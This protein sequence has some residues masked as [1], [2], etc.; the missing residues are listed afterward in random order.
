MDSADELYDYISHYLVEHCDVQPDSISADTL[1]VD[2]GVDSLELLALSQELEKEYRIS[3]DDERI[4]SVHSLS[5]LIKFIGAAR[6]EQRE[7]PAPDTD[8]P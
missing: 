2:L 5:D 6:G 3:L 8:Q 7:R 4:A 1:L